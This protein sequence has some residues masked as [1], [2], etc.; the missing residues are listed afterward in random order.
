MTFKNLLS[1]SACVASLCAASGALAQTVAAPA[2]SESA[3]QEVE[4][5]V[6][7]GVSGA[8]QT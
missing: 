1:I 2:P 6:V 3:S 8:R 4:T 5:I 7:Y